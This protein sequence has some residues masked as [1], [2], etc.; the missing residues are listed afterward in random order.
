M[1]AKAWPDTAS[2]GKP[3][4]DESASPTRG[5]VAVKAGKGGIARESEKVILK[6]S[7]GAVC[8]G[9]SHG[10]TETVVGPKLVLSEGGLVRA[11]TRG[12]LLAGWARSVPAVADA[13]SPGM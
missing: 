11:G 1:S 4:S 13:S 10:A 2:G 5:R 12:V 3:G 7:G 8:D 9:A 6:T